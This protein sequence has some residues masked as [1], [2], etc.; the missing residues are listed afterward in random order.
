MNNCYENQVAANGSTLNNNETSAQSISVDYDR[1]YKVSGALTKEIIEQL[2][3]SAQKYGVDWRWL[4]TIASLENALNPNAGCKGCCCGMFAFA[5]QYW[6]PSPECKG[7]ILDWRLQC[8][9]TAVI[10]KQQIDE[11]K[12]KYGC[13]DE[14]CNL[15]ALC[16]HNCGCGAAAFFMRKATSKNINGMMYVIKNV[17]QSEFSKIKAGY[18]LDKS[19][20]REGKPIKRDEI[21][22]Y[23]VKGKS[24][25]MALCAKYP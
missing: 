5:R 23:V 22:N 14:N 17:P 9:C 10:F 8:D 4:A 1:N 6:P 24:T 3:K 11:V 2:K 16:S 19:A 25:Y 13:D 21:Y 12:K 18:S 15:Y 7:N 20:F